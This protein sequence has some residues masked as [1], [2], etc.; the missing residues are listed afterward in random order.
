MT[1]SNYVD[2]IDISDPASPNHVSGID[3]TDAGSALV[4]NNQKVYFGDAEHLR[5]IDVSNPLSPSELGVAA[6]PGTWINDIALAGN[7]AFISDYHG[8]LHIVDITESSVPTL[9]ATYDR[10]AFAN[11][12]VVRDNYAYITSLYDGFNIMDISSPA[13]LELV[14]SWDTKI[15]ARNVDLSGNFAFVAGIP[16]G[17]HVV[18]ISNPSMPSTN[19][20]LEFSSS[21]QDVAIDGSYAFVTTT[22]GL[23]VVDISN[24]TLLQKV[25]FLYIS[26]EAKGIATVGGYAYVAAEDSGLHIIDINNPEVPIA[27]GILDTPGSA[28]DVAVS[29]GYAYVADKVGGVRI[30]D[31]SNPDAPVERSSFKQSGTFSAIYDVAVAGKHLYVAG[32]AGLSVLD[33]VDPSTPLEVG[34]YNIPYRAESVAVANGV[35]YVGASFDGIYSLRYTGPGSITIKNQA[36]VADGT[37]FSFSGDLGSFALESGASVTFSAIEAGE[38]KV[39]EDL[40]LGW[41]LHE[42]RCDSEEVSQIE[43]GVSINLSPAADITCTFDN[44][45]LSVKADAGGP[46]VVTKGSPLRLNASGSSPIEMIKTYEWDCTNDGTWD[47]IAQNP[48]GSTCTYDDYGE[49]TLRLRTWDNFGRPST[50]DTSVAVVEMYTIYLPLVLAP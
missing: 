49:Y 18:N 24:P 12:I 31:V 29:E 37:S 27:R 20:I 8:G 45:R 7:H 2:I 33:V 46:Y 15:Y 40:P 1:W 48:Q 6:L 13:S 44:R 38:Y 43:N 9:A 5:I 21:V 19:S 26:G 50:D 14:D 3:A 4:V 16:D 10:P 17:L 11:G 28:Q 25:G 32:K 30:I 42:V 34:S 23:H 35:A 41:Y 36:D 22:S 47:V 39:Q